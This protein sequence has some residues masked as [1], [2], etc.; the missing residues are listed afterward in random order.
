MTSRS[1]TPGGVLA[2]DTDADG[3]TLWAVLVTLPENVPSE[4]RLI[5]GQAGSK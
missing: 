5:R 2:N 1:S 4:E 3:D